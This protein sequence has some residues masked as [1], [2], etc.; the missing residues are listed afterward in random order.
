MREGGLQEAT[1]LF[2]ALLDSAS[3]IALSV[4][5]LPVPTWTRSCFGGA[6]ASAMTGKVHRV[7]WSA[8]GTPTIASMSE[9]EHVLEWLQNWYAMQCDGDWEHEWGVRIETLDN[10]GWFVKIDL[11]ETELADREHPHQRVTRDEHDWVMAWT[12]EQTFH[13]ACG[14]G[15]LTEGLS[16]FRMWASES[17]AEDL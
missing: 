17:V 7:R 2:E 11:E 5:R 15:N 12:S 13:I 1:A 10:P 8:R 9:S 6:S 16:L 4:V 3:E 14:P